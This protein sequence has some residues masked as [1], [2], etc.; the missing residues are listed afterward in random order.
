MGI[1]LGGKKYFFA[2]NYGNQ[3][4]VKHGL[5]QNKSETCIL[6]LWTYYLLGMKNF[7]MDNILFLSSI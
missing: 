5:T 3:G 1:Q 2:K 7:L 4:Y 6:F